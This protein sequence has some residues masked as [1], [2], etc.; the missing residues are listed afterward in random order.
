MSNRLHRYLVAGV[1]LSSLRNNFEEHV[2]QCLHTSLEMHD[3]PKL[4]H[5]TVKDAYAYA[6]NQLPTLYPQRD[7]ARPGD[8]SR[9]WNIDDVVESAIRHV[10]SNPKP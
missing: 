2:A 8:L 6:L 3:A 10:N 7:A 1:D 5:K 9:A 4:D